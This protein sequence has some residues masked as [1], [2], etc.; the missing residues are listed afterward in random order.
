M[1]ETSNPSHFAKHT[2]SQFNRIQLLSYKF[3]SWTVVIVTSHACQLTSCHET[4]SSTHVDLICTAPK[5]FTVV[6]E[7][8]TA[9]CFICCVVRRVCTWTLTGLAHQSVRGWVEVS[10]RACQAQRHLKDQ[11]EFCRH[12]CVRNLTVF[13]NV[14][15]RLKGRILAGA[16][17]K[18]SSPELTLCA[19][20]YLVSVRSPCYHSSM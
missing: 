13:C 5:R 3:A 9:I 8:N 17:G 7:N 10:Y 6:F 14:L 1:N 12:K 11:S 4:D 2:C 19:D 18:F 15:E 16:A 20:S